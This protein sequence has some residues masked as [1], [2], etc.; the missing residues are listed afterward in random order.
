MLGVSR[1]S[2]REA[3]RVFHG[4]GSV[5]TAA[6]RRVVTTGWS[7]NGYLDESVMLEAAPVANEIRSHI[8]QVCAELAAERLTFAELP[9]ENVRSKPSKPRLYARTKAAAKGAQLAPHSSAQVKQ[10]IHFVP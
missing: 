9:H 5:E 8:A 4:R 3:L 6:G 7:G 10:V 1:N 2:L